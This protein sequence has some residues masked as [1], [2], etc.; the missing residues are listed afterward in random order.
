MVGEPERVG[1]AEAVEEGVKVEVGDA[2]GERLL[3]KEGEVVAQGEALP[4]PPPALPEGEPVL[5]PQRVGLEL[6]EGQSVEEPEALGALLIEAVVLKVPD[7]EPLT[8]ARPLP[9]SAPR[10]E[11][12]GAVLAEC[13]AEGEGVA[14][15][16]GVAMGVA[17]GAPL[18]GD[19]VAVLRELALTVGDALVDSVDTTVPVPLPPV[20]VSVAEA[21]KEAADEGEEAGERDGREEAE[22]HAV[23]TREGDAAP[24]A[25]GT[26]LVL[27]V[28][29]P[30]GEGVGGEEAL[31]PPPTEPLG[32]TLCDA[33]AEG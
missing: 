28:A 14:E 2:E 22:A 26:V 24:V 7:S 10:G 17:V 4:V 6:A 23:R 1:E 15:E 13:V 18:V 8:E 33:L 11:K 25:V 32:D 19:C 5:E 20:A 16:D 27:D 12:L 3:D 30:A 9:L 31:L 29:P 21:Q